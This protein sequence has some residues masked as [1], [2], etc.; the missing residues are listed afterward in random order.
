MD[1]SFLNIDGYRFYRR[2]RGVRKDGG[3]IIYILN[4][5]NAQCRA[6]IETGSIETIWLEITFSKTKSL[7]LCYARYFNIY[8]K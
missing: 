3:I 7:L 1:N 6:D 8:S 2:D 4:K 5:S